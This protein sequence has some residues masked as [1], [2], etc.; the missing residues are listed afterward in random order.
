MLLGSPAPARSSV[1]RSARKVLGRTVKDVPL[2][3]PT[4]PTTWKSSSSVGLGLGGQSVVVSL[5]GGGSSHVSSLSGNQ[6]VP[7]RLLRDKKIVPDSDPPSSKDVN[8]LN[9]FI[10][11]STRLMV[12]TGAGISTECGIPDYRSPNGAY[13]TG[14]RP[15]THQVI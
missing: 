10:D 14:F 7:S 4:P 9:Q 1:F 12:L 13:S 2:V 3:L 15:I 8:L 5:Q 11:Q 6:Q